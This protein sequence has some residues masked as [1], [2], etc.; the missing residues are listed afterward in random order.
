MPESEPIFMWGPNTGPIWFTIDGCSER[1]SFMA[2]SCPDHPESF[3]E[4]AAM[5]ISLRKQ[6]EG[7]FWGEGS[8]KQFIVSIIIV[9]LL[10]LYNAAFIYPSFTQFFNKSTSADAANIAKQFMA[11][12]EDQTIDLTGHSL[13]FQLLREINAFRDTFGLTKLKVFSS[14]GDILFSTDSNEIGIVNTEPYFKNI[15]AQGRIYTKVVKKNTQSL[16]HQI[17]P[18]DIVETY[19]PLMKD[20]VFQGAFEIYYDIT[21]KKQSLDRLMLISFVIVIVIAFGILITS[22]VSAV[23]EKKI[24]IE[25]K[26]AQEER[27]KLIIELQGALTQVRTLNGLLPICASCKKIRDDQGYWNQIEH[28]ISRHSKAT[29]SHGICPECAKKLYGEFYK[30]T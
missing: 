22:I 11:M 12:F 7:I 24:F 9:I 28:Y 26:R 5:A 16:E 14:S 19:V 25:R 10:P 4:R 15:V 17:M 20:G 21:E 23:K 27:E 6:D 30:G 29:F 1:I 8:R 13:D 18:V 3:Q 2:C